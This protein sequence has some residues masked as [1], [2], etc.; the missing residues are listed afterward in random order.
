MRKPT[1]SI[2]ENEDAD[3][4]RGNCEAAVQRLCFRCTDCTIPFYLN[5]KIQLLRLIYFISG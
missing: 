3:Q 1:I 4:L 2:G 5:T